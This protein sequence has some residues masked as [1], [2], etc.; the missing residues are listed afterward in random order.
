MNRQKTSMEK[1]GILTAFLLITFRNRQRWNRRIV[2]GMQ[3]LLGLSKVEVY[4]SYSAY[5]IS[6]TGIAGGA[7]IAGTV[8]IERTSDFYSGKE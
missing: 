1:I 2:K 6:E 3:Q 7:G 4:S 8:V 5:F